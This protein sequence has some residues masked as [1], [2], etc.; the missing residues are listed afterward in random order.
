MGLVLIVDDD[1]PFAEVI[2]HALARCGYQTLWAADGDEGLQLIRSSSPGLVILDIA[3]PLMNGLQVLTAMRCDVD[4]FDIPVI[5]STAYTDATRL[6]VARDQG[7]EEYLIKSQFS[8]RDLVV[9]VGRILP[10]PG[11]VAA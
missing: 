3:M 5:V 2:G 9:Q 6:A 4:L 8:L 11:I 10:P 7:V 1:R